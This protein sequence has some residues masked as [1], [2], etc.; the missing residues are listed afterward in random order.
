MNAETSNVKSPTVPSAKWRYRHPVLYFRLTM[1][2]FVFLGGFAG[3]FIACG[4]RANNWLAAGLI[5]FGLLFGVLL[6]VVCFLVER[7]CFSE[8]T[9]PRPQ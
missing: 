6:G 5:I 7:I 8:G 9:E 4:V 1:P 3:M 2:C